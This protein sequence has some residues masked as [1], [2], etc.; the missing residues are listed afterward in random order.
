MVLQKVL[1]KQGE[2]VKMMEKKRNDK[3]YLFG[4][5]NQKK[6]DDFMIN[7]AVMVSAGDSNTLQGNFRTDLVVKRRRVAIFIK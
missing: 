2:I 4:I 1:L 5:D 7:L 3:G 6:S